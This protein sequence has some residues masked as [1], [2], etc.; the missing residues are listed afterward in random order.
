M[1][2]VDSSEDLWRD[3]DTVVLILFEHVNEEDLTVL[4]YKNVVDFGLNL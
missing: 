1:P 2:S 3:A 4:S